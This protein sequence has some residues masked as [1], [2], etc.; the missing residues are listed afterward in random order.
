MQGLIGQ[1]LGGYRIVSQIGRGGMATV[2]KAYQPSLDRDVAVKVMPPYYAEQDETFLKRFKQEAKAIASLRH[3]NILIVIDYG[4]E[5]DTTYIVMEFVEAGTLTELMGKPMAPKQMQVLIDQ[6]AGALH[7][8]HEQ[9]VVHRDIKPSNILLPKQDW[10]LLTDFGLARIVGGSQLTQS[11]TVAGTPAYMSPEQGRGERVDLRSDIYSLGI[12]LYEMATGVVPFHAETPMAIV[13]KHIIDPLPLPS[14]KNP[15]LPEDIERVILKALS[16]DPADRFQD[17]SELAKALDTAVKGL[18]AGVAEA[19]PSVPVP[20]TTTI[21]A[22]GDVDAAAQ[23]A[24]AAQQIAESLGDSE[25]EP[26]AQMAVGKRTAD[27]SEIEAAA[28]PITGGLLSSRRRV[29]AAAVGGLL[30]LAV[31]AVGAIQLLGGAP[32][33]PDEPRTQ[34]QLVADA[35]AALEG[36]DPSSAI[37]DLDRAIEG[38]PENADLFFERARAEAA[39]GDYDGAFESIQQGIGVMPA[40]AWAREY[41]ADTLWEIGFFDEAIDEYRYALEL[42]PGAYW[43]YYKIAEIYQQ[44]DR[45]DEAVGVLFEAI[46]NPAAVEDPDAMDSFGWLLL[47]MQMFD[48]AEAAFWRATEADPG[49]PS[50]YEGLMEIAYR[51]GGA[52]AGIEMLE[53]GIQQFPEHAP[54]YESAGHWFWELGDINQAV[55]AFNRALELDPSNPGLYGS[56]AGVLTELGRVEEA[57]L[58]IQSGLE[59][60]PNAP[61]YYLVAADFYFGIGL[62][63]EAILMY[64]RAV[65]LDPENAW[66]YASLARA[67]ASLGNQ[68]LAVQ[69]LERADARNPGDPWL[70]EFI[71]WTYIDLGDCQRAI[72]YLERAL[73]ID[74][75]IESADQGIR[76]CGG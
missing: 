73:S 66:S 49:N 64:D 28:A 59:R 37:E 56:L 14:S 46:E 30:L 36:D 76:E 54:F 71:G 19:V 39:A 32:E 69:A 3:P 24:A 6:V 31:V 75:S 33:E 23:A 63:D 57:K 10:P 11:G 53:V 4:E 25:V 47:D 12:V 27:S 62:T 22:T 65:E 15:E 7:Y 13:V 21:E 55:L 17:A 8:A 68:D 72:E 41:A 52:P 26:P 43:L 2:F 67:E 50:R 29:V 74:P 1:E 51:R 70:D 60:Y 38:D 35:R 42:D 20:Q 5:N 48:E 16:K 45:P 40:E 61:E 9:G 18:P 34:E 44:T 58:L